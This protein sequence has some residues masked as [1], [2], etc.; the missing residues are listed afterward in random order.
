MERKKSE[1]E[2]YRESEKFSKAILQLDTAHVA[3]RD[4]FDT[5]I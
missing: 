3:R 2:G 4:S 5:L 1:K